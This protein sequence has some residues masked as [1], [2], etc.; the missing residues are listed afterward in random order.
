MILRWGPQKLSDQGAER[1]GDWG[2]AVPLPYRL[3][4]LGD[5]RELPQ[6]SPGRIDPTDNAFLAYLRP[7]EH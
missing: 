3:R 6:R 1:D 4:G 2:G 5:R 7:T